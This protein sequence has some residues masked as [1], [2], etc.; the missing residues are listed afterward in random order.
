MPTEDNVN[1]RR[2][3]FDKTVQQQFALFEGLTQQD[4]EALRSFDGK[5]IT[6]FGTGFGTV[7]I[8]GSDSDLLMSQFGQQCS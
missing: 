4:Q 1:M 7:S 6:A 8:F 3:L 2:R 5:S